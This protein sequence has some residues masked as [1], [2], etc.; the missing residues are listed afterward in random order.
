MLY[1]AF[2]VAFVILML[3]LF[4]IVLL[5]DF[6]RTYKTRQVSRMGDTL[7][8]NVDAED[9]A[10]LA[11]QLAGQEDVCV[12]LLDAE[13]NELASAEGSRNCFI[14][15]A[16]TA[17]LLSWCRQAEESDT[18]LIRLFS[19]N[20]TLPSSPNP[21][22]GREQ[23]DG[24]PPEATAANDGSYWRSTTETITV[25]R[26]RGR[27]T[28]VHTWRGERRLLE[29]DM[30]AAPVTS[31]LYAKRL[32]LA[33]G[34]AA[35]L[36]LNTQLTPLSSTVS[37]LRYQLVWITVIVL[38]GALLLAGLI[39]RRVSTPIIETNE[40]AKALS[41]AQYQ[42]P[43]HGDS[44]R[45]I[46]ELNT[47]LTHAAEELGRVEELQHE[48]IANISHD[49]RTPLTMIG[50]Y[51]EA[52]RDIP[53][54]N[55]PE[56]MQIIIDESA[57]LSTLVNELLDFSRMQTGAVELHPEPFCLTAAVSAIAARVGGMTAKDGYTVRFEPEGEL[58]VTADETRVNQVIYNLI[59]NALTYTGE[60]KLVTVAQR[61]NGGFAHI[62]VQDTG[63]GIAPDE[64]P[65]IWNRYYR[66]KETHKRAIIGS[67]L[68]LNIVQSI[69]E[70][71]GAPYG[72]ESEEGKGTTFW[73]ELP[74]AEA[75]A[76]E[77]MN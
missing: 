70:K 50:G 17:Y 6:Y 74:L 33:D 66:T 57:R 63:K 73:F 11:D 61:R 51:A 14:H 40:A 65:L 38:V 62:D 69:L 56:N 55:T 9:F 54:E 45:E 39:S 26:D 34:T 3:W 15:K 27:V 28:T 20:P 71:H 4:Q 7:I 32:T 60:D 36:L 10:A 42:K 24:A 22:G 12:E 59:G 76:S 72:V 16:S 18:A 64:L 29:P 47:T 25:A 8:Q 21:I 49:L 13:G 67:G 48:L 77:E 19:F 53:D 43:R 37:A 58:W 46:S 41:R 68:G 44:Y 1:L 31:L 5:D 75:P 23:S 30:E 35:T 2:F 52:M